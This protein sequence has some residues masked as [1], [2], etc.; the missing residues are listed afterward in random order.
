MTDQPQL[1]HMVYF[2]LKD[3]SPD[4]VLKLVESCHKY[5]SDHPGCVYFS[6]GT[7]ADLAREVNDRDFDVALNVVFQDRAA[8][9]AYQTAPKHL[10]FVAENKPNWARVRVFDSYLH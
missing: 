4:A 9:D 10:Q 5:L 7:L 3:R 8:H 2:S 6:A 1:A